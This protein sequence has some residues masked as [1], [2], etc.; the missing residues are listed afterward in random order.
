M[1]DNGIYFESIRYFSVERL[2]RNELSNGQWE[3]FPEYTHADENTDL[4][5]ERR[6]DGTPL[7]VKV[8]SQY[9]GKPSVLRFPWYRVQEVG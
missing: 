6:A 2:V 7:M 5:I 1:P 4:Y 8:V 3:K 9:E